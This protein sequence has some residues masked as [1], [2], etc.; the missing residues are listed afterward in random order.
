MKSDFADTLDAHRPILQPAF[1]PQ[2]SPQCLHCT[3]HPIGGRM[4]AVARSARRPLRPTTWAVTSP[5][6]SRSCEVVPM[7]AAVM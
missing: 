4:T 2:T 6:M 1:A 7:S 3:K 5:T